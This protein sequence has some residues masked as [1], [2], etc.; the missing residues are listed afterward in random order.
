[1]SCKFNKG[2]FI[3]HSTGSNNRAGSNPNGAPAKIIAAPSTTRSRALVANNSNAKKP[4]GSAFPPPCNSCS[5]THKG[6]HMKLLRQLFHRNIVERELD[7]ELRYH[8]ERETQLNVANG[9]SREAA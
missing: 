1:M 3:R 7:E 2:P 6:K 4:T 8:V 5:S 9:M